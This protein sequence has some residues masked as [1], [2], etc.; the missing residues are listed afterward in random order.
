MIDRDSGFSYISKT[1]FGPMA[2]A[3]LRTAEEASGKLVT[4]VR[5]NAKK[6]AETH[7]K[8]LIIIDGPPGIGC[9][10]ISSITGVDL[11]LIVTEPTLSAIHDLER[12]LEVSNHFKIP[13]VVCVNKYDVNLDNTKEIEHYC[14]DKKINIVGKLPYNTIVTDSMIDEKTL[15]EYSKNEIS[16]ATIEMWNKIMENI[17]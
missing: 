8:D 16:K 2:H 11:V 12:I 14:K 13:A 9:P 7:K 1:R 5:E 3:M 6:L 15:I 4:V 17:N 10:V